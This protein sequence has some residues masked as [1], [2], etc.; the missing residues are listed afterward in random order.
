[1]KTQEELN[2]VKYA[3]FQK[4][5]LKEMNVDW[6]SLKGINSIKD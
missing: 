1:M 6:R 4:K 5:N 3:E 2:D